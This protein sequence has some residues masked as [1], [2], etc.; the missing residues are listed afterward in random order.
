MGPSPLNLIHL[1]RPAGFPRISLG[2]TKGCRVPQVDRK[3]FQK[4]PGKPDPKTA[5]RTKPMAHTTRLRGL[6]MNI[7]NPQAGSPPDS[8]DGFKRAV[9]GA[10]TRQGERGLPGAWDSQRN[11]PTQ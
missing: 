5:D 9:H 11:L 7:A 4:S 10:H 8:E 2:P 1:L 3:T 6:S